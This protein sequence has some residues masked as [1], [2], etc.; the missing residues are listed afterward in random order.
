MNSNDTSLEASLTIAIGST[1]TLGLEDFQ[2]T[3]DLEDSLFFDAR[4][5]RIASTLNF[6][7]DKNI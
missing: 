2:V 4:T 6:D 1:F 5:E 7:D 3:H